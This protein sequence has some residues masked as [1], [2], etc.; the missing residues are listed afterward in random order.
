MESLH[1]SKVSWILP[2]GNGGSNDW[3]ADDKVKSVNVAYLKAGKNWEPE[4]ENST[5]S[6]LSKECFDPMA[7]VKLDPEIWD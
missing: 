5:V 6:E 3:E 4:D 1:M 2:A 7:D